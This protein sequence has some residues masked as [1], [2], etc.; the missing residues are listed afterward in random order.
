MPAGLDLPGQP[1]LPRDLG[2]EDGLLAEQ[3][4][5]GIREA[6]RAGAGAGREPRVRSGQENRGNGGRLA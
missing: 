1:V 3:Y 6:R 5:D 2:A 4:F